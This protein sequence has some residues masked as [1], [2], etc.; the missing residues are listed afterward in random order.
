MGFLHWFI[1][2]L[3]KKLGNAIKKEI[4]QNA[5]ELPEEL[6]KPIISK[7]QKRKLHSSLIDNI[8]GTNLAD[9]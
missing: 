2:F 9:M 6:H 5:K 4:M 7:F 3:I 1:I 8:W